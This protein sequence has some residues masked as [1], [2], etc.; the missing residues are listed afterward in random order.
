[1]FLTI[2]VYVKMNQHIDTQHTLTVEISYALIEKMRNFFLVIP[3][4]LKIYHS[5]PIASI[6]L[7]AGQKDSKTVLSG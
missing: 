1:M 6:F 3:V 7:Y 2:Y 5:I 4:V